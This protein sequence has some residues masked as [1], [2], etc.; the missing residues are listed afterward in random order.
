MPKE[1]LGLTNFT[2]VHNAVL[3]KVGNK[4]YIIAQAW[5]PGDFAI[6]EQVVD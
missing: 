5:N 2:H 3:H 6:L 1:D 4:Y